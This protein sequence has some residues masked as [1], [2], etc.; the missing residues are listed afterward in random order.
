MYIL[1]ITHKGQSAIRLHGS[2]ID[3]DAAKHHAEFLSFSYPK[4]I[5]IEIWTS[6]GDCVSTF[7]CGKKR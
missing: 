7:E 2:M 1:F 6:K 4:D 5:W 3:L